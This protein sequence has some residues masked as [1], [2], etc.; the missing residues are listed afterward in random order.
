MTPPSTDD[1]IAGSIGP[2]NF[3]LMGKETIY[4]LIVLAA[5]TAVIYMTWVTVDEAKKIFEQHH[6]V[7]IERQDHIN[8]SINEFVYMQTLSERERQGLNLDMPESL[9]RKIDKN[10][11][12]R[13]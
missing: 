7:M 11:G 5:L 12:G 9:R 4:L 1:T 2:V 8:D 10:K 13:S 3:R 6:G